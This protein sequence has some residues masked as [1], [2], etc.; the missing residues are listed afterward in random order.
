MGLR[1]NRPEPTFMFR[2]IVLKALDIPKCH[3]K[4]ISQIEYLKQKRHV[5]YSVW[6]I[7]LKIGKGE[8]CRIVR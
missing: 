3:E 7:D 4:M 2:Q 6:E 5:G 1:F 8:G